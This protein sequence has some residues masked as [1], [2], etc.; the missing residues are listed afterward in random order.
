MVV[1]V[2]LDAKKNKQGVIGLPEAP[3]SAAFPH[4]SN[5]FLLPTLLPQSLVTL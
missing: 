3:D 1:S 4:G 2:E 5:S